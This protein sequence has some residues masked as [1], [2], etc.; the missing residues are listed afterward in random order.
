MINWDLVQ[1]HKDALMQDAIA[2]KDLSYSPYSKYRVGAAL[3]LDDGT[4]VQG[5][6]VENA[7]YGCA[8]CAERTAI[9]KMKTTPELRAHK[10][11]AVA[12]SSDGSEP[13]SPCGVCRQ[14]LRE[15]CVGHTV[16]FMPNQRWKPQGYQG[17]ATSVADLQEDNVLVLDMEALLPV[18]F[19]PSML[20]QEDFPT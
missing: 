11:H 6:N 15:F 8:I 12:V 2:A 20:G 9:V 3:L 14:V 1:T 19:G 7:S 4:H 17:K 5:A 10:I 18:S 16:F 13:C